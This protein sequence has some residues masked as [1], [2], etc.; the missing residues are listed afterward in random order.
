EKIAVPFG[1][2]ASTIAPT[3]PAVVFGPG[4]IAQAHTKDEWIEL[5]QVDRATDIL[6]RFAR[7]H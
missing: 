4:D 1:T 3:I 5:A 7:G 2:D 6:F